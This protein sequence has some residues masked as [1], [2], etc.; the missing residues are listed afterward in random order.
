LKFA[1]DRAQKE[2]RIHMVQEGGR[3][4]EGIWENYLEFDPIIKLKEAAK[5]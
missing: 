4:Y 2:E 1:L 3:K 5:V